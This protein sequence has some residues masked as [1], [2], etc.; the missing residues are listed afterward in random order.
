MDEREFTREIS[1]A[2]TFLKERLEIGRSFIAAEPLDVDD[3]F[4]QVAF[5]ENATYEQ[6]FR[7]GLNR[8][9]YITTSYCQTTHI[10][11]SVGP[12][13]TLGDLDIFQTHG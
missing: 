11:N 4:Q 3:I 6:I 8:S 2:W 9:N 5:D 12:R 13:M 10:S 1:V 7:T